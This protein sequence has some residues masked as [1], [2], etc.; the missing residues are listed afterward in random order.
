FTVDKKAPVVE[1]LSPNLSRSQSGDFTMRGSAVD[2]P[3]GVKSIKYIAGKQNSGDITVKPAE[4]SSAWKPLDLSG[5]SWDIPFTGTDNITQKAKAQALGKKVEG[6]A[7]GVELYDIPVFFLVEDKAGESTQKGN[8]AIITKTIRVDPNGDIPEVTVLSPDANQVLGGTIRISGTVSVPNPA[9]GTVGSVWIQITD[10]KDGSGNPDFNQNATFD[11]I[12]WCPSPDGKQL[13]S[14]S[15]GN[16]YWSVEINGNKEFEPSTGTRRTIWFRLR[17]KNDKLT[18]EPGQWTEP[19]EI[20]VDKAAPTITGMKVATEAK[21]GTAIPSGFDAE[22]QDYVSNMWIKGDNLYLCADLA[23]NAGIEQID[24]SGSYFG[25]S[26]ITLK[27]DS[28]I[29]GSNINGSGKAWFTQSSVP[30]I[31]TAKNYKMRIPLKTTT[32][33]GSNNGFTVNVT[34]KA[35]KQGEIDGLT[36]QASFSLK[37]D[38]STPTAV[39]GTK[40]ASSGTIQVSETSFT[41]PALI[42]KTNINTSTKFFCFRRGYC[43][44]RI[45]Q[46]YR[47]GYACLRSGTS[48][49]GLSYLQ[50]Y[51]IFA[52]GWQRQGWRIRSSL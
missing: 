1:I 46:K 22:N 20:V 50:P 42:G 41:D 9:A 30:S 5:D 14:Y 4:T 37:Y 10:K 39:F 17:G 34:I 18:P 29:T 52:A 15:A 6:L 47:Q 49:K 3:S 40:I 43:N 16:P 51:R 24:I 12:N 48:H 33:P 45:R 27:D 26:T 21:I 25:A 8:T 2:T 32:N 13:T 28:Q 44:Y 38:N 23:H 11:T 36:A 35:K 7:A 31:T 19:V